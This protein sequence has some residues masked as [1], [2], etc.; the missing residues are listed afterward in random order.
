[1]VGEVSGLGAGGGGVGGRIWGC[2]SRF[3]VTHPPRCLGGEGG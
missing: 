1:M 2:S 3:K